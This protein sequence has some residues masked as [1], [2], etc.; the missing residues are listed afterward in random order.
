MTRRWVLTTAAAAGVLGLGVVA[1]QVRCAA[2]AREVLRAQEAFTT[3]LDADRLTTL[4]R[5]EYQRHLVDELIRGRV[6]LSAAA[7]WLAEAN[8]T[9]PGWDRGLDTQL[10]HLPDRR[11]RAAKVLV[12]SVVVEAEADPARA[13][14]AVGRVTAEYEDMIDGPAG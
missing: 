14:G 8:E 9:R 3:R 2:G 10:S 12:A 11:T 7:D 4:D 5:S 1:A 6:T 13:E